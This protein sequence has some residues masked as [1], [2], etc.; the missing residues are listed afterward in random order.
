MEYLSS[1]SLMI[2]CT[3]VPELL[4]IW[5]WNWSLST[6]KLPMRCIMLAKMSWGKYSSYMP[7]KVHLPSILSNCMVQF[8]LLFYLLC[9]FCFS[10]LVDSNWITI[11]VVIFAGFKFLWISLVF[12]STKNNFTLEIRLCTTKI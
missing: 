6:K 4:Y 10:M 7:L 12:L 9:S 11:W 5:E 2:S 3:T 8:L 1:L